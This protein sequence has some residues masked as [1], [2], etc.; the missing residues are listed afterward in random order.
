MAR[1]YKKQP[2]RITN[3]GRTTSSGKLDY[4]NCNRTASTLRRIAAIKA[5]EEN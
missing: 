5:K 4:T 2:V 3:S 1:S